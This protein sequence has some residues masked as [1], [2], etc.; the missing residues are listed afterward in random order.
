MVSKA[1]IRALAE[2]EPDP[3]VSIYMPA[4]AAMPDR[5]K[6]AVRLRNL[7]RQAAEGLAA[8]GAEPEAFLAE[9]RRAFEPE[10]AVEG[11]DTQGLAVFIAEGVLRSFLL[12]GRPP[13]LA[14]VGRGFR[15][16]PLVPFAD[17]AGRY[18]VL[19]LDRANPRLWRG[20]RLGLAPMAERVMER[21]L[22]EIR[23]RTEFP[24][25]IGYHPSG[26]GGA[27]RV[28]GRPAAAMRHAQGESAEDYE[29]TELDL[30]A[31]GIA[32]A[33]EHRLNR[34]TAPLVPVGEP[35]LLGMFRRHCRHAGLTGAALAKAPAG[36][37]P[38]ELHRQTLEIASEALARPAREAVARAA[39]GL[40]RADGSV[41]S[42][43]ERILEA[44]GQGRVATLLVAR[45]PAGP[46][47]RAEAELSG[48]PGGGELCEAVLRTALSH[49]G[50]VMAVEPDA[51]PG[52][53]AMAA[54]LR[55]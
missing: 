21:S 24:A 32:R 43:P 10:P 44:T 9:A 11:R 4:H 30:F 22:D 1:D 41:L 45:N 17:S 20:D 31:H 15:L 25:E 8:R 42:E 23:G 54:L 49:G 50:E 2:A 19:T 51:L 40:G 37:K 27:G 34:E 26:P 13:E 47:L 28:P 16:A 12:P 46:G 53:A 35:G 29:Q 6:N 5:R 33:V 18:F 48:N 55:F 39:E 38:A 52:G 36:L 3:A 14:A 7:M